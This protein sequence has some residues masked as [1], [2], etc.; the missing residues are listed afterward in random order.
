MDQVLVKRCKEQSVAKVE[1]EL[2]EGI[3]QKYFEMVKEAGKGRIFELFYDAVY[4]AMRERAGIELSQ[5]WWGD[6]LEYLLNPQ[7]MTS[8]HKLIRLCP[9]F[10][11][12]HTD[13]QILAEFLR[14][15]GTDHLK[16]SLETLLIL[17]NSESSQT[18][19][20]HSPSLT[21]L[22]DFL[23]DVALGSLNQSNPVEF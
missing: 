17:I 15:L 10:E 6:H 13:H 2:S 21:S 3:F 1:G 5:K 7:V 23:S 4:G 9:Y 22:I 12:T 19:L 8:L 11:M 20:L 16:E 14:S 18:H